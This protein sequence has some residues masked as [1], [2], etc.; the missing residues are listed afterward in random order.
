MP[1]ALSRSQQLV[2]MTTRRCISAT[3]TGLLTGGAF[4]NSTLFALSIFAL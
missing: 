2:D 1:R 3:S 4:S